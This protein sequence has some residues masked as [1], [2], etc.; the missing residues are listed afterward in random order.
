[1]QD[2]LLK[3]WA[4]AKASVVFV[5]HDLEEAI[6]LA[7]KVYVLTAGPATVKA[8]YDIDIPR[9]RV[10]SEIRYEPHFIEISKTIW[11]DL[12]EEVLISHNRAQ[13]A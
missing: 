8:V 2:E 5:T 11:N 10:S 4:E 7:D 12:R 3:L 6:A 1:M 9:P 13:A